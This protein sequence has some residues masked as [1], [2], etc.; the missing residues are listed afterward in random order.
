MPERGS[1][2][3][4]IVDDE[5]VVLSLAQAMLNRYGYQAL[6]AAS[7]TEAL[8]LFQKWPDLHIDLAIIDIVM[9]V[10]D[11]L[12]LANRF[13]QMRPSL[14]VLYITSYASDEKLRPGSLDGLP[15]LRKPFT[16]L[17]LIARVRQML[18]S[19]ASASATSNKS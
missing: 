11:G 10:V 16:S 6:V 15:L 2:T 12:E 18:D 17:N 14:P 13:R 8:H 7:S 1:E 19:Q 9:P 3:I 5:L 4:L